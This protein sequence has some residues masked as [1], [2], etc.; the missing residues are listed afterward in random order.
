MRHKFEE[1]PQIINNARTEFFY[2]EEQGMSRGPSHYYYSVS[3][4]PDGEFVI[5]LPAEHWE[6]LPN[7]MTVMINVDFVPQGKVCGYLLEPAKEGENFTLTTK[8][9]MPHRFSVVRV[10]AQNQLVSTSQN[11]KAYALTTPTF[12]NDQVLPY[13]TFD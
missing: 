8:L 7:G 11:E 5:K 3:L 2:S 12:S 9:R 1:V 13:S 6:Q 4:K 10:S